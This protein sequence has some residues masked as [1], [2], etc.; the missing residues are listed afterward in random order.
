MNGILQRALRSLLCPSCS[1]RA[2]PRLSRRSAVMRMHLFFPSF[3]GFSVCGPVCS[4]RAGLSSEVKAG[5]EAAGGAGGV[6][7]RCLQAT[8]PETLALPVAARIAEVLG[9]GRSGGPSAELTILGVRS[10]WIRGRD[11]FGGQRALLPLDTPSLTVQGAGLWQP[12]N[13]VVSNPRKLRTSKLFGLDF[14]LCLR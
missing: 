6:P 10:L 4:R 12:F 8:P 11:E 1:W 5:A 13:V 3:R 14:I 2:E 9:E 7:G